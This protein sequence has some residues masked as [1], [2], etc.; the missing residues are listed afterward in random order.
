[1]L[2]RVCYVFMV[3]SVKVD[4]WLFNVLLCVC[5]I[6]PTNVKAE[7]PNQ[8]SS[9]VQTQ[10]TD[11]QRHVETLPEIQGSPTLSQYDVV[12]GWS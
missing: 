8:P 12:T 9:N 10:K 11:D 7:E 4:T 6:D 1:M 3:F 5:V 2:K